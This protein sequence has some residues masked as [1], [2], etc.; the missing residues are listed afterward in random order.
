MKTSTEY[1]P[2]KAPWWAGN[3]HV[4][5]IA[6]SFF[7]QQIKPTVERV[8]IPTPDDDFLEVDV[9]LIE[10][11]T[12]VTVLFHGLEGSSERY[13]ITNLMHALMQK[14]SSVVAVNFRGCG[15]R[16]NNQPFYY[17]A[18]AAY[19]YQTVFEWVRNTMH[20]EHLFAVGFSLGANAL[21]KYQS[22]TGVKSFLD[23]AVAVS[24]PF[25]LKAG[26]IALQKGIN[27]LYELNFLKTL[28]Q[29][30][31]MKRALFPNLPVFTG[32]SLYDFDD[33]I[34][35]KLHHYDDADHYYRVCSSRYHYG[36]VKQP[37]LIIHSKTD[38]ICPFE[39]APLQIIDSNPF[40]TP[41]FM[42]KGGHVGFWH[43]EKNWI[44]RLISDWLMS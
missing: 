12:T 29:K 30:L 34:T 32:N 14:N 27:R 28:T 23:K 33:Q 21:V 20:P 41:Y 44:N 17:N 38:P 42:D 11:S 7:S 6:S 18:G 43:T 19:D 10:G 36:A 40:I 13:Y 4:Q 15:S 24:P 2:F 1:I 35:A 9:A 26:S 37:M 16:I 31:E 3:S 25:D 8:E 5:T 22:E 39:Y